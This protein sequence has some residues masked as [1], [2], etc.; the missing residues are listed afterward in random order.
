MKINYKKLQ[1]DKG[2]FVIYKDRSGGHQELP[3]NYFKCSDYLFRMLRESSVKKGKFIDICES[4]GWTLQKTIDY[5]ERNFDAVFFKHIDAHYQK[6]SLSLLDDQKYRSPE[7]LD[8][9]DYKN[10]KKLVK[11][12][13]EDDVP[14]ISGSDDMGNYILS[15]YEFNQKGIR[16]KY[17][18]G[19]NGLE[20]FE[21]GEIL[22]PLNYFK[23]SYTLYTHLVENNLLDMNV[24]LHY[25]EYI[26][27]EV[28]GSFDKD[29]IDLY[30]L[31]EWTLEKIPINETTVNKLIKDIYGMYE[32]RN[33]DQGVLEEPTTKIKGKEMKNVKNTI[34]T[35]VKEL[36]NTSGAADIALG[37][38]LYNN[39]KSAIG[40]TVV[41]ISFVDR[42][43]AKVSKKM[44]YKNEVTELVA[45]LT[46]LVVLKQFY[47]HKALE[48]VRGYIVN[49]LYTIGIEATGFDD[50][51]ALINQDTSSVND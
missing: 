27:K 10:R 28:K 23:A 16:D 38:L 35:E 31:K 11:M 33:N 4:P 42:A 20:V 8:I 14:M 32:K 26:K 12:I 46:G 47:D 45:I 49:R 22:I 2:T 18:V 44:K 39:I 48:N 34:V 5:K 36:V 30:G 43:V 24:G 40:K 50:V 1:D 7:F 25:M 9:D 41:K 17:K 3:L 19:D 13:I 21:M 51:L 37:R 6:A 29:N 15:E